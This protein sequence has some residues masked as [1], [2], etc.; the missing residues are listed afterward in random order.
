MESFT[1]FHLP[2]ALTM[3]AVIALGEW[4]WGRIR[5]RLAARRHLWHAIGFTGLEE[6]QLASYDDHYS[7]GAFAHMHPT[8]T[9]ALGSLRRIQAAHGDHVRR[10]HLWWITQQIL[11]NLP[12]DAVAP[13]C[14]R[15]RGLY[16]DPRSKTLVMKP[17]G[18]LL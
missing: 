1:T 13:A 6:G 18:G 12:W 16:E 17:L 8:G 7:L 15:G 3:A 14:T 2:I 4:S 5:R 9:Q 11:G 10:G